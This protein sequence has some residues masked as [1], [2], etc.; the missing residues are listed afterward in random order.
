M[1]S[2]TQGGVI[3]GDVK[4]DNILVF[5]RHGGRYRAKINDFGY[6]SVFATDRDP[7]RMPES[8]LWTAPEQ[9]HREILASQAKKMDI[10]SFGVLCLWI[11]FYNN[12]TRQ[13]DQLKEHL[14]NQQQEMLGF[15]LELLETTMDLE[16][17]EKANIRSIF[18][19]TLP[20]DPAQR[21]TDFEE[22]LLCLS[23]QRSNSSSPARIYAD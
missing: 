18:R 19:S 2:L 20:T 4:P 16:N 17:L 14:E 21:A 7:L 1:I 23:P 9:H 10:Y 5:P 22:L 13:D 6:S 8:G 11:F 12:E 15:A 3:H